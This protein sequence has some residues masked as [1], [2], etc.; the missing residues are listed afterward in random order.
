V[1]GGGGRTKGKEQSSCIQSKWV[2]NRGGHREVARKKKRGGIRSS[3]KSLGGG[4][5]N[6]TNEKGGGKNFK[7]KKKTFLGG[8]KVVL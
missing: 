1:D 4:D 2:E 6:A 8:K 3:V 5:L 7:G